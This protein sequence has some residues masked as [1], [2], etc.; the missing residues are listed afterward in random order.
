[1]Y[2]HDE[3]KQSYKRNPRESHI[4]LELGRRNANSP[5]L[6]KSIVNCEVCR[7][8][9]LVSYY[10]WHEYIQGFGP[11]EEGKMFPLLSVWGKPMW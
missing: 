1:M 11:K 8:G 10:Q 3:K 9:E 6:F 2:G 4:E 7:S 5:V